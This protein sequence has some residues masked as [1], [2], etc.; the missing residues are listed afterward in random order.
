MYT[1][2]AGTCTLVE[3]TLRSAAKVL[4]LS[5]SAASVLRTSGFYEN[6]SVVDSSITRSLLI[7]DKIIEYNSS[8]FPN[9]RYTK[10]SRGRVLRMCCERYTNVRVLQMCCE[11]YF[12]RIYHSKLLIYSSFGARS[13]HL[14]TIR[15]T[16]AAQH[17]AIT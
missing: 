3:T 14:I 11:L 8:F 15:S 16:F 17:Q 6:S 4:R 1:F 10:T 2:D 13:R 12:C 9:T 7:H 5:Q